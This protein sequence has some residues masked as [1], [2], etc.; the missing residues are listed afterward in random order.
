MMKRSQL[1]KS[2]ND[3]VKRYG[4]DIDYH[5]YVSTVD[6]SSPYRQRKKEFAVTPI[7]LRCTV[8]EL[9]EKDT[10]SAIGNEKLKQFKL[11]TT[12]LL[13]KKAFHPLDFDDPRIELDPSLII[14]T[15]DKI[16]VNGTD[17]RV[18][19]IERHADDNAGPIWYV[20]KVQET[21]ENV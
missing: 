19:A 6:Y 16:L 15:K 13:I 14:S 9:I 1:E 21:V 7:K 5:R 2:S 12:P 18:S 11:C 8:Q 4:R 17:C 20:I 10:Y 3:F